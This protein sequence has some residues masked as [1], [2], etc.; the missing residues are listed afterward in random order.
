MKS[1][2][3]LTLLLPIFAFSQQATYSEI[4]IKP[5]G[6][7]PEGDFLLGGSNPYIKYDISSLKSE[8]TDLPKQ[9]EIPYNNLLTSGIKSLL[10]EYKNYS[11]QSNLTAYSVFS[12][13]NYNI[14]TPKLLDYAN[15]LFFPNQVLLKKLYNWIKPYYI[16]A[17]STITIEEQ[18]T[19]MDKIK[20]C[21]KYIEFVLVQKNEG[22]YNLWLK[23][24]GFNNDEKA[25]SF[26]QRRIDK[27]QWSVKD[28]VFWISQIK[29]D[30]TP[31]LKNAQGI[32]SHYEITDSINSN[33][34]I[35]VNHLGKYAILDKKFQIILEPDF[36]YI[37]KRNSEAI[38][39]FRTYDKN[40]FIKCNIDNKGN[41]IKPIKKDWN[42]FKQLTDSTFYF[43]TLKYFG[44]YN[45]VR[46]IEVL[47]SCK[48]LVFVEGKLL[49]A[50]EYFQSGF[51]SIQNEPIL[52]EKGPCIYDYYGNRLSSEKIKFEEMQ[53][54]DPN[55]N[56]VNN[57]IYTITVSSDGNVII[58]QNDALKTG[59][60]DYKGK[61]I[62]P[63][64]YYSIKFSENQ[65]ILKVK[66]SV[67]GK[68]EKFDRKGKQV[69]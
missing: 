7:S 30:F 59:V 26:L 1:I 5:L 67:N 3:I 28:C 41:I 23:D 12:L 15:Q 51:D 55:G 63:F 52:K 8:A 45:F 48:Y 13:G 62:L 43:E 35:A 34:S 19:L 53:S 64:K 33:Y 24:N 44:I 56:E 25:V 27:K 54:I 69:N 22:K 61:T 17:F 21:E 6:F 29:A 4:K 68:E 46:K 49:I 39:A 40:D 9:D 50:N 16:S 42:D 32:A 14:L 38:E 65:E 20:I 66:K 60:I 47:D 31:Y 18:Q 11:G 37:K 36:V 10:F 2:L 58:F 57:M